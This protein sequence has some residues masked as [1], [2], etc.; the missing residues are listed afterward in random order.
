MKRILVLILALVLLCPSALAL[1]NENLDDISFDDL[2]QYRRYFDMYLM[3]RPEFKQVTVPEGIYK[4]GVDIPAGDWNVIPVSGEQATLTYFEKLDQY[5]NAPDK[6]AYYMWDRIVN[7]PDYEVKSMHFDLKND[8]YIKID[9][10]PVVF[11]KYTG[12]SFSFD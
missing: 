5:G 12:P 9:L 10:A 3:D 8:M 2:V 6:E 11:T 7:I 1:R 4:I